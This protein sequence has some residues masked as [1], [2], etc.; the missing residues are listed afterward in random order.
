MRF[1]GR[2]YL[3]LP[4][5]T[6]RIFL[7]FYTDEIRLIKIDP[8]RDLDLPCN[9]KE[10]A[11]LMEVNGQN[12]CV[13]RQGRQDL[14][15]GA[16]ECQRELPVATGHTL[17]KANKVVRRAHQDYECV[18]KSPVKRLEGLIFVTAS[19][20]GSL[21]AM[22]REGNQMGMAVMV[23]SADVLEGEGD[24]CVC[25]CVCAGSSVA[26][27]EESGAVVDGRGSWGCFGRLRAWRLCTV[28]TGRNGGSLFPVERLATSCGPMAPVQRDGCEVRPRFLAGRRYAGGQTHCH[29]HLCAT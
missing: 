13:A 21:G 18:V 23:A 8:E 27:Y 17:V 12:G 6:F 16:A 1:C 3:Q 29:G 4:D 19:D 11:E 9:E 7:K 25:V 24:V 22:P 28:H 5:Y 26:A 20:G 14:A 2:E 15:F 10:V